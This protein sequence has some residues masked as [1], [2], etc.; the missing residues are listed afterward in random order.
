MMTGTPTAA[1]TPSRRQALALL[2]GLLLVAGVVTVASFAVH[3][4]KARAFSLFYGSVFL[5]DERGPVSVDLAQPAGG[6]PALSPAPAA[7]CD[8]RTDVV[9]EHAQRA[10]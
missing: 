10:G 9:A 4:S 6:R 1:R 2:V 7:G 8:R 5:N 3:P